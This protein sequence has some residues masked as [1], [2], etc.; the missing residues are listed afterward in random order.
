[1]DDANTSQLNILIS[2]VFK[3]KTSYYNK[4][5]INTPKDLTQICTCVCV[6]K[7]IPKCILLFVFKL[8]LEMETT[9]VSDHTPMLK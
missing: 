2:F 8:R 9:V 3:L 1:M 6:C 4:Y 7:F 5:Y